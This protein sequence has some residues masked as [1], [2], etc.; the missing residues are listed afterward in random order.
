MAGD[1]LNITCNI[2]FCNHQV[3]RDFLI[4]LHLTG[5]VTVSFSKKGLLPGDIPRS[6]KLLQYASLLGYVTAVE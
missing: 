3:H 1:T 2:L 6:K 5:C 4:I